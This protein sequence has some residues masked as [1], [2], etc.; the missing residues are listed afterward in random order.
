MFLLIEY[1]YFLIFADIWANV[2]GYEA[3]RYDFSWHKIISILMLVFVARFCDSF[4]ALF[5]LRRDDIGSDHPARLRSFVQ[6]PERHAA[7]C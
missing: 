5:N 3:T 1:N 7:L 6:I 4:A 2:K